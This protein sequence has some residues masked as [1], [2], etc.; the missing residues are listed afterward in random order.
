MAEVAESFNDMLER[1]AR[2]E[3][4]LHHAKERLDLALEAIRPALWDWDI[5]AGKIYVDK[6]VGRNDR[7]ETEAVGDR[8]GGAAAG[9]LND[10]DHLQQVIRSALKGEP[11]PTMPST[12]AHPLRRM[13]MDP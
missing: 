6:K 10:Q 8:T 2:A 3:T 4:E 7:A 12:G 9:A 5:P 1:R 13:E 11:P